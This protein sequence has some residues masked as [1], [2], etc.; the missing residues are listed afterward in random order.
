MLAAGHSSRMGGRFKLLEPLDG[1][2][3]VAHAVR[4][5]LDSKASR[6]T[7]VVGAKAAEVIEV[8]PEAVHVL[9]NPDPGRGLAS[10][11]ITGVSACTGD[12]ALVLLGDT[13]FVRW[14]D[15]DAVI[16]AYR[17]G[18]VA[19]AT[20]DGDRGHPVLWTREFFEE[21]GELE[22]DRGARAIMERHPDRVDEVPLDNPRLLDDVDTPQDLERLRSDR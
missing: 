10:S 11:L 15:C 19:V 18:R 21:I 9:R 5:A 8:L 16:D 17:P 14:T 3:L 1:R 22:G 13:P 6:V 2:P 7:V 20:L 12:A 4:A